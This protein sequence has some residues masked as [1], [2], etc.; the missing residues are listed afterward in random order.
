MT[1]AAT[2]STA[3][4]IT[5]PSH[6]EHPEVPPAPLAPTLHQAFNATPLTLENLT[7]HTPNTPD[8][9]Q[10]VPEEQG[11]APNEPQDQFTGHLE[12][13]RAVLHSLD[14]QL[15]EHLLATAAFDRYAAVEQVLPFERFLATGSFETITEGGNYMHPTELDEEDLAH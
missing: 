8:P 9:A 13:L 4:S 3:T 2:E 10:D 12:H 11:E 5:G 6:D 1:K 14:A 15:P 7:L